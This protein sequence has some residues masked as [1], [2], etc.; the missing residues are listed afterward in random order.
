MDKGLICQRS[1][2]HQHPTN[3]DLS[4]IAIC[5]CVLCS[6]FNDALTYLPF[7]VLNVVNT[8]LYSSFYW[9][10]PSSYHIF[11]KWDEGQK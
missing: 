4:E 6:N 3:R 2:D 11:V 10:W 7:L 1:L 5:Y 9:K 8:L